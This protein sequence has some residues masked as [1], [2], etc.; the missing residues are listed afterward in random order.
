MIR[1]LTKNGMFYFSKDNKNFKKAFKLEIKPTFRGIVRRF[2]R[3]NP[4]TANVVKFTL[5]FTILFSLTYIAMPSIGLPF[6]NKVK[7]FTY[8]TVTKIHEYWCLSS[9]RPD[10]EKC[11]DGNLEFAL[12]SINEH[13]EDWAFVFEKL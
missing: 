13:S 11:L 2:E 9:N 3:H 6:Q 5:S 7:G 10:K 12:R 1:T 4:T 8:R